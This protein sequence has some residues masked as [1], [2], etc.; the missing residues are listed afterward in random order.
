MA[1]L[2]ELAREH[3]RIRNLNGPEL[4]M[5]HAEA[6]QRDPKGVA[7]VLNYALDDDQNARDVT[8]LIVAMLAMAQH[9]EMARRAS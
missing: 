3:R 4:L 5:A 1:K 6:L 7:A 8:A 2:F 9:A